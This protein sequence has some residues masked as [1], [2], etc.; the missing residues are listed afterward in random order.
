MGTYIIWPKACGKTRLVRIIWA[1]GIGSDFQRQTDLIM[2]GLKGLERPSLHQAPDE[3]TKIRLPSPEPQTG[4][5]GQAVHS[6]R[7]VR[8]FTSRPLTQSQVSELLHTACGVT[9][10]VSGHGLRAAPSA[11]ALYPFEIYP[12][13]M[14]VEGL[15]PGIYHYD[16]SS[17]AV[18]LRA[19]GD[20][21]GDLVL[22]C[23]GQEFLF[24]AGVVFVLAAVFER[25]C[26]KYGDRGYRYVYMEA[27]HISQN[28]YL[29]A[30]N[31]GLGTVAIGAF[32]DHQVNALI[33]LDGFREAVLYMQAVGT[34]HSLRE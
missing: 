18:E 30:A 3:P 31:L 10:K 6:R 29:Q 28:L 8:D 27:G 15:E 1:M 22:A 34:T 14:R 12:V 16:P 20:L 25:T 13:V 26:H 7:S 5:L 2:Q 33:G 23:L 17:H 9:A 32:F 21:S 19:R 11:G 24:G 4:T